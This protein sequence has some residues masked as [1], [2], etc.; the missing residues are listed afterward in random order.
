M[1]RSSPDR[2]QTIRVALAEG[3]TASTSFR[4]LG[5]TGWAFGP[6]KYIFGWFYHLKRASSEIIY[7]QIATGPLPNDNAG[8]GVNDHTG[9][10]SLGYNVWGFGSQ[11]TFLPILPLWRPLASSFIIRSPQDHF[12]TTRGAYGVSVRIGRL[13][14]KRCLKLLVVNTRRG[15]SRNRV[16]N[17]LPRGLPL[18]AQ[19]IRMF[20]KIHY[21]RSRIRR[22]TSSS[23]ITLK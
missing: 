1:N 14:G 23:P 6:S 8:G 4:G 18:A 22:W 5:C 11:S 20:V 12:Y 21:F 17:R 13:R 9:Q 10:F 19:Q 7:Q 3:V 15:R 16:P 2:Y